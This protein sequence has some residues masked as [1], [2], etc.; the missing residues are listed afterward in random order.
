MTQNQ[1]KEDSYIEAKAYLTKYAKPEIDPER[2]ILPAL[3]VV[4]SLADS[5]TV[6]NNCP[7]YITIARMSNR[8]NLLL[9]GVLNN[10]PFKVRYP[11]DFFAFRKGPQYFRFDFPQHSVTYML[12]VTGEE[13]PKYAI[14]YQ[15]DKSEDRDK[16][17][18]DLIKRISLA[19]IDGRYVLST[20]KGI[21]RKEQ[22]ILNEAAESLK[23]TVLYYYDLL[24]QNEAALITS[25]G[26]ASI[27]TL[28]LSK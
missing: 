16:E 5:S 8:M 28:A 2:N 15:N 17:R 18:S 23:E 12:G 13:D 27:D 7:S 26:N 3:A 10:H 6:A 22:R 24:I 20:D 11:S 14:V 25:T 21:N 19:I 9:E 1:P 4:S